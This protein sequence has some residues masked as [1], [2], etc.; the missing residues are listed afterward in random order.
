MAKRAVRFAPSSLSAT[1][2]VAAVYE[3]RKEPDLAIRQLV[4]YVTLYPHSRAAWR[5]L[6]LTARRQS[7][8]AWEHAASLALTDGRPENAPDPDDA[9][10]LVAAELA[11]NGLD[12]AR[13]LAVEYGISTMDLAWLALE[14]GQP[15][16]AARQA[17]L[18]L[19]ADPN[20]VEAAIVALAAHH[21]A[22]T[23]SGFRRQLEQMPPSNGPLSDRGVVAMANLVRE[24]A[25][26]Q[27]AAAFLEGLE[28]AR[29]APSEP[30]SAPSLPPATDVAPQAP[31]PSPDPPDP[32]E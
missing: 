8:G 9:L 30:A 32:S 7:D 3:A 26:E 31:D 29:R 24:L 4:A 15:K 19:G 14:V 17:E 28:D 21:Q 27:A 20:N 12:G 23:R 13:P 2:A 1:S 18:L 6:A 16:A 22:G 10:A 25:G 5:E 11:S